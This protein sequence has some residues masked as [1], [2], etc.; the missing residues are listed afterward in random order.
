MFAGAQSAGAAQQSNV[1]GSGSATGTGKD[2]TWSIDVQKEVREEV[3]LHTC[4]L[5]SFMHQGCI[6]I[7][8]LPAHYCCHV[9]LN[10]NLI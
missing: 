1:A 7:V 9:A 4:I 10:A 3:R 2:S 6:V 5:V 8:L